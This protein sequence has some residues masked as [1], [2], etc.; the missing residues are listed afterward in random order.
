MHA[1]V[2]LFIFSLLVQNTRCAHTQYVPPPTDLGMHKLI[3]TVL[4]F[5][6]FHSSYSFDTSIELG[7]LELYMHTCLHL[8]IL[9]PL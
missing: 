4:L 8:M 3:A 2:A 5:L 1:V 9:I 7:L 6:Y